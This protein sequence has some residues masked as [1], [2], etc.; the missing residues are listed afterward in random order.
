M[1]YTCP[2]N[3]GYWN[4]NLGVC[5]EICLL[6]PTNLNARLL[7][8]NCDFA[9]V[10]VDRGSSIGW[11]STS[12]PSGSHTGQSPLALL[13]RPSFLIRKRILTREEEEQKNIYLKIFSP[14]PEMLPKS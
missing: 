4:L 7:S 2:C 6:G 3:Q 5:C 10:L 11:P 12:R 13:R 8:E 9:Q 14:F 1:V